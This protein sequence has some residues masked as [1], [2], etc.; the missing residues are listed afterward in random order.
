MSYTREE[1][2]MKNRNKYFIFICILLLSC[3][4]TFLGCKEEESSSIEYSPQEVSSSQEVSLM[5]SAD[6]LNSSLEESSIEQNSPQESSVQEDSSEENSSSEDSS[7]SEEESSSLDEDSSSSEEE[8]SSS[9]ELPHS[10]NWVEVSRVEYCTK[11]GT[12]TY[13][14]YGCTERKTEDL[15]ALNHEER[16]D[17]AVSATCQI[18]GKT[19]GSHCFRCGETLV[20]QENLGI[21]D[22]QNIDYTCKWCGLAELNFKPVNGTYYCTGTDAKYA[23]RVVIPDEYE[24]FPVTGIAENAFAY[25]HALNSLTIGKNVTTIKAGAFD[26]CDNLMEVYDYSTIEVTS[27]S[28]NMTDLSRYVKDIYT[29]PTES[30][31][32]QDEN[33]YITYEDQEKQVWFVGYQGVKVDLVIPDGVTII[34]TNS[35]SMCQGLR[36]VIISDTVK[37]LRKGSFAFCPDLQRVTIGSG[38]NYMDKYLFDVEN[39]LEEAVFKDPY[40]WMSWS[41]PLQRWVKVSEKEIGDPKVACLGLQGEWRNYIMKKES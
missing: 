41:E 36:S 2:K 27:I 26:C 8:S 11:T 23:R 30:R 32:H 24:G 40:N 22:H 34:N 15:P 14:C 39:R 35:F 6:C 4:L 25:C 16:I 5:Q 17:E 37:T 1:R 3:F 19:E 21:S 9:E 20:E 12:L 29:T 13:I 31:L 38:V 28:A 18:E 33:G 10:H 7:S